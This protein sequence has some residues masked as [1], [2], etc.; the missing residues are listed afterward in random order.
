[1]DPVDLRDQPRS[2][3]CEAHLEEVQDLVAGGNR[4]LTYRVDKMLGHHAVWIG[5]VACKERRHLGVRSAVRE[6][7]R[8]EPVAKGGL[9]SGETLGPANL[10]PREAVGKDREVLPGPPRAE[11]SQF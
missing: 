3:W 5:N 10:I 2:L 6:F 8:D 7:A 11:V 1:M 4:R 9:V